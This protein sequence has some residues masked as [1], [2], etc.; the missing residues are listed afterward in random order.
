MMV[1][2]WDIDGTLIKLMDVLPYFFDLAD[3]MFGMKGPREQSSFFG[4]GYTDYTFSEMIIQLYGVAPTEELKEHMVDSYSRW[5]AVKLLHEESVVLPGVRDL[6]DGL[7]NTE[8]K[9]ALL[10]GNTRQN[11]G[12]KLARVNLSQYFDFDR[13]G[14]SSR[15]CQDRIAVAQSAS[16]LNSGQIQL[17]IGDTTQDIACGKAIGAR[18]IAVATGTCSYEDLQ[19]ESPWLALKQ[20]PGIND[21]LEIIDAAEAPW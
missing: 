14:Y 10:T 6:L 1:I 19:K 7:S 15:A 18:T 17:V 12:V 11:A 3:E 20:L 9:S 4:R 8:H 2:F 5:V 13:G 16:R 21:F